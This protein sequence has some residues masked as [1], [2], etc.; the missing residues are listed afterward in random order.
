VGNRSK[1]SRA[2]WL[3]ALVFVAA[4]LLLVAGSWH[5]VN[6]GPGAEGTASASP[7]TAQKSAD[8]NSEDLDLAPGGPGG[9]PLADPRGYVALTYDD[10]PSAELTPQLLDTLAAYQAPATFFVLGKRTSESP[11]L[12]EREL[13]DGHVVG[14]HTYDHLDLTAIDPQQVRSQLQ[15]TNEELAEIDFEPELYRP[16]YDRHNPGVDAIAEELG[17]TRASWTYRH[18]PDDREGRSGAGKPASELCPSVVDQAEPGDVILMHDRLPGT[19]NA[20]PCI[21]RGL[22]KQGLEPGRL[23]V[24]SRPSPRNGDSY[25]QVRP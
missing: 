7:G 22:R 18:D 25:I 3:L 5:E 19:V 24:S 10:G 21:I 11:G 2:G 6:A 23:E 9:S 16:P 13:A 17:L 20:A 15:D 4:P 1:S 12:V 14:N 8:L